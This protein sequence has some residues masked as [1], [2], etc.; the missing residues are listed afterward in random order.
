MKLQDAIKFVPHP[1]QQQVLDCKN[2]EVVICAGRGWGKSM[3]CGYIVLEFFLKGIKEVKEGKRDGLKIFIIAPSYEL[4]SKVFEHFLTM[5]LKFDKR[6]GQYVSGGGNR[7]YNL[8]MSESVWIQCKSTTEPFGM[9]GERVDLQIVDEAPIVPDK[10]YQQYI[11]PSRSAAQGKA[12]YIGTPRG[13]N[14]FQKKFLMLKEKN[15]SF[16]FRSD[17]GVHYETLDEIKKDYPDLLFRQEYLAEFVDEA[18][19]V[20]LNLDDVTVPQQEVLKDSIPGHNYVMGVDLGQQQDTTVITVFDTDTNEMVHIDALPGKDYAIQKDHIIMKAQRYN[21]ARVIL[22]TTGVGKPISDDLKRAGVFVEDFVFSGKS[23]E[24][25]IGK[26]IVYVQEKYIKIPDVPILIDELKAFEYK[27]LNE[28]TGELLRNLKY[29]AP[30][31]Y[32]D[33]YVD[34]MSLAIWGLNPEKPQPVNKMKEELKKK[35]R[36]KSFI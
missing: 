7:P 16:H 12:Y 17:E 25:L 18:G 24:E 26:A 27:Y 6:L 22:D 4:T 9:L 14:W 13:K 21:T 11:R 29:G 35:T 33:D 31:G 15:A 20:F 23:K 1:G 8:K 34:S 5:L 30:K 28:R 3:C 19:T 2:D 10:V 36:I 32:H